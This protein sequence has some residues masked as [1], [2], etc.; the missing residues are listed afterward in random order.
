MAEQMTPKLKQNSIGENII[1]Y[2]HHTTPVAGDEEPSLF[3][4]SLPSPMAK[5]FFFIS[6][7]NTAFQTV[8]FKAAIKNEG[9]KLLLCVSNMVQDNQ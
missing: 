7:T 1:S 8:F 6:N 4:F 5:S 9:L 3:T 2:I